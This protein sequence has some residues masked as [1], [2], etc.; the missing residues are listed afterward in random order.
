MNLQGSASGGRTYFLGSHPGI[1][2]FGAWF[3][4]A[5]KFDD[6][7]END[8]APNGTVLMSQFVTG[9]KNP[10]Y[11]G[12]AYQ[13]GPGVSW[14]TVNAYLAANPS[15]F[16][17]STTAGG[18]T[19]NFDLIERVSAGYLM[20]TLNFG[21]FSLIAGVRF[22]GTQ[23][24]TLS[25]DST[26]STPCLCAKGGNSYVDVLPSASLQI[27]LDRN[28]DIRLAYGRG[29]SRP[30][31]QFLTT[32]TSLDSSTFPP[33]VTV[34]N[35]ALKPEHANNYDLLYE[36]YL[37]PVGAIRAGFFYKSLTDPIVNL[38]SAPQPFP[39]CP[40]AACFVS[41]AG[42]AGTAYIAGVEFSFEQHFT[43]LPGF[44]GGLGLLA[45]Y[46][47]TTSQA[48]NV[49]PGNRTDSPALLRQAPNT[50]NVSPTFDRGRLS[51]RVGMAYNGP[52]IYQYAF[53]DGVRGGIKGPF[54]DVYLFP[55]F[56]MDAQASYRLGKGWTALFQGL[57]LN[58]EVFGF[59]NG[60]PQYFIQREYYG[61]TYTF[62]FRW[63]LGGR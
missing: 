31:P 13:Y 51:L 42:N 52:N 48:N 14:E 17:M 59:Y 11:Y 63:D 3:S 55:H 25:F 46:S 12:G 5:H 44:L 56:Q 15:A 24:R 50:W 1:F 33:T 29:I 43:Y 45:N 16:T 8:F 57:N 10:D 2:Q 34:G 47:Y 6:S 21:R 19:N 35:P 53:V 18:N 60:S 61:P 28:S 58:N 40:Q 9:F 49:N 41:Q 39:S 7:Y 62:G 4:D 23:D 20:N 36:R 54:G 27:G 38:L 37:N 30:D 22:E 26:L 32:A